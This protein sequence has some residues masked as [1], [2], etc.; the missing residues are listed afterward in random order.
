M[1]LPNIFE[2][3]QKNY[4]T[5]ADHRFHGVGFLDIYEKYL[6]TSREEVKSVLEIGVKEGNS[7]RTWRE[8]FPN[9]QIRG[10]DITPKYEDKG[11]DRI[12]VYQGSQED[13]KV[14]DQIILDAKGEFDVI[15]D[16]GSHINSLTIKSFN[17]LWPHVKSKG[18]Y[19]IEDLRCSYVNELEEEMKRGGWPGLNE[20]KT[21][22]V[23][24]VNRREDM[25][26]F[27]WDLIKNM[28]YLNGNVSHLDFWPMIAV[29]Q[30]I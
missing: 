20:N 12:T 29:L 8:Y 16:D 15:I 24:L 23:E 26:A 25:Q 21:N 11:H 17:Y 4:S 10:V 9:A 27:F 3:N 2:L 1:S 13:K 30:K 28:D 19:F 14:L 22:S 6:G 18:Y 7:L 5:K